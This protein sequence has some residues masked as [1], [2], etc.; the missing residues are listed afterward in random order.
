MIGAFLVQMGG[1]IKVDSIRLDIFVIK[2]SANNRFSIVNPSCS[3]GI[4][5][6][7]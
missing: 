5:E 4:V 1:M 7:R 6:F 3:R 2:C